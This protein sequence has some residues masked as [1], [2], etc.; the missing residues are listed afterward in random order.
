MGRDVARG[1]SAVVR[2]SHNGTLLFEGVGE[3]A[4]AS[5]GR[6]GYVPLRGP[7]KKKLLAREVGR[8]ARRGRSH[9]SQNRRTFLSGFSYRKHTFPSGAGG[10]GDAVP[11][12]NEKVNPAS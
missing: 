8:G 5:G 4:V 2:N 9:S 7:V 10:T 12:Q 11:Q 3:K 6:I 1:G